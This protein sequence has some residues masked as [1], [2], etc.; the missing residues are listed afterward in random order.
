MQYKP[1]ENYRVKNAVLGKDFNLGVISSF[2]H[3]FTWL[4]GHEF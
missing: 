1:I 4:G 3:D 2:F